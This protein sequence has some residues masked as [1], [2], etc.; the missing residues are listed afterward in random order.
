MRTITA[1][2]ALSLLVPTALHADDRVELRSAGVVPFPDG[3]QP[4]D[5][6]PLDAVPRPAWVSPIL[7][8]QLVFNAR[9]KPGPLDGR[10]TRALNAS[11][12]LNLDLY[13]LLPADDPNLANVQA[14]KSV[15][16]VWFRDVIESFSGHRWGGDFEIGTQERTLRNGMVTI[17]DGDPEDFADSPRTIAFA[18]TWAYTYPDGSFQ[19]WARSEIV[20]NP[21]TELGPDDPME[22]G[23]WAVV[24]M[25]HELGHV[26][27][28]KHIDER[29]SLMYPYIYADQTFSSTEID[30]TQL[31]YD[32]GPGVLYP[33]FIGETERTGA[34]LPGRAAAGAVAGGWW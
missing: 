30:H 13:V 5:R 3:R 1:L 9:D 18:R 20:V 23:R 22:Y 21:D 7:W 6:G 15:L 16:N 4:L 33:G 8:D 19:R 34:A 29:N 11:Q 14:L 27:G 10:R 28:F 2:L 24:L 25:G 26:L 17:R 12:I 31:A 32:I